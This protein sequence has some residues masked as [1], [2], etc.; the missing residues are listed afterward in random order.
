MKRVRENPNRTQQFTALESEIGSSGK[1][2]HLEVVPQE[3]QKK[4]GQRGSNAEKNSKNLH[5][6]S[7]ESLL[8]T[9]PDKGKVKFHIDRQ[10]EERERMGWK[11]GR[12]R[13]TPG[14]YNINTSRSLDKTEKYP[15]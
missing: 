8:S 1:L 14:K 7:L 5:R 3:F 2:T 6:S 13:Q 12:D 11:G 10:K 4:R 15:N 9:T